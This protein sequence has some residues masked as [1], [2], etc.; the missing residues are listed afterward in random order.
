MH[1]RFSGIANKL[2]T[3]TRTYIS[4][5]WYVF[6]TSVCVS[7]C[8]WA[9]RLVCCKYVHC[10]FSYVTWSCSWWIKYHLIFP[11]TGLSL[12]RFLSWHSHALC[13]K[14]FPFQLLLLC[15]YRLGYSEGARVWAHS[16]AE[17]R[18]VGFVL[19]FFHFY[20]FVLFYSF[21]KTW[22]GTVIWTT[23]SLLAGYEN[24]P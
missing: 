8:A 11:I 2:F 10:L 21:N 6:D 5:E 7:Y 9:D 16:F 22:H 1:L 18:W 4:E 13:C 17:A 24:T 19:L 12:W 20:V 23:V 14:V 15:I 3:H